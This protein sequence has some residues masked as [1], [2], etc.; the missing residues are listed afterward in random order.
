MQ[1]DTVADIEEIITINPQLGDGQI[2]VYLSNYRYMGFSITE[3]Y[4]I[5][6]AYVQATLKY[7]A[8]QAI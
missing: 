3:Q 8:K 7:L 6:K 5:F 1:A 4:P 2:S